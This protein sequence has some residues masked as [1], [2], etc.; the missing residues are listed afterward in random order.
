M[1]LHL[2]LPLTS[3]VTMRAAYFM[4]TL[5]TRAQDAFVTIMPCYVFGKHAFPHIGFRLSHSWPA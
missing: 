2:E 5:L 1:Y 3:K 4:T